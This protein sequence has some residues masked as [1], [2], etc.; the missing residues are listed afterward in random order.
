MRYLPH[1]PSEI[2]EML[3]VVGSASLDGLFETVPEVARFKGALAVEPSLDEPRLMAHLRELSERNIGH[4]YLSFL[5]AGMYAHHV[6]PAVDQLLLRSEFYTA[7]TPYQPEV[8]QGTLQVIW[9]FQT[10]VSEL[11]G[12]PL[13]NASMYD[14]ASAAAEAAAAERSVPDRTAAD[15]DRD[16]HRRTL[17]LA[18]ARALQDLQLACDRRH[19]ALLEQTIAHLDAELARLT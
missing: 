8:S 14:G 11:Y 16:A 15:R 5:G 12:L 4:R 18:R 19:R 9:E 1:T 3:R 2:E 6:P 7:Y 13:A 10:I 17:Q